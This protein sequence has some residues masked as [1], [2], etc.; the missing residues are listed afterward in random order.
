[1]G[2]GTLYWASLGPEVRGMGEMSI[3]AGLHMSARI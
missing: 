1:M 2:I 3:K